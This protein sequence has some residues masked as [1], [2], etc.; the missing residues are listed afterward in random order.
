MRIPHSIPIQMMSDAS[1]AGL[2]YG[3]FRIKE[4][5]EQPQTLLVYDVGAMQTTATIVN[6][7]LVNESDSKEAYP[8][9]SIL[10][11]GFDRALGGSEITLR[12]REHLIG[13]FCKA[14]NTD[15]A[16]VENARVMAKLYKEAQ[17]VKEVL[18]ANTDHLAQIESLS[19]DKDLKIM[20][21]RNQLEKL[22]KDLEQ[23]FL[24]PVVDALR[25]AEL[26]ID[27]VDQIALMGA[28]TR[29][30]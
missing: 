16:I 13:E 24:Q 6:Y 15:V 12:L 23:R 10:G 14:T 30:T 4:I 29:G 3:V 27:K 9:M 26:S 5:G 18:S 1:A 7:R 25:M 19:E 22:F 11:F 21:T 2:N 17:R 8:M 20:V 28:G